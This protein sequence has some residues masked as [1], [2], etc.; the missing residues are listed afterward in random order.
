M[1]VG[2]SAETS[3]FKLTRVSDRE[4]E[5]TRRFD[6]P[7]EL[8]WEV[9]TKP[10]H[11]RN[12]WGPRGTSLSVCEIDLRVGGSWRFALATP[13]G[14]VAFFGTYLEIDAPARV[15]NTEHYDV[16]EIR[17][18]P[19]TVTMTLTER[20]GRTFYRV[21]TVFETAEYCEGAVQSGMEGGWRESL[22]RI[23]EI[24]AAL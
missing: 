14:E 10:E 7:R 9:M 24:V 17:D 13:E 18:H 16:P 5:A 8:V 22:D 3:T 11:V 1:P 20:D 4:L 15:V 19:A 2:N 23:A 12:W 21:N 6:A